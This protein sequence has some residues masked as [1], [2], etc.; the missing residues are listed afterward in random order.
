M[1]ILRT[2]MAE[3]EMDTYFPPLAITKHQ[4]WREQLLV[5]TTT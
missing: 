2:E 5:T 1:L 3:L 4:T